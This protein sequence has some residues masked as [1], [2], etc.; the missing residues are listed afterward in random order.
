MRS[1]GQLAVLCTASQLRRCIWMLIC[2]LSGVVSLGLARRTA[3]APRSKCTR[4][5]FAV[6]EP[7]HASKDGNRSRTMKIALIGDIHANLVALSDLLEQITPLLEAEDT[8]D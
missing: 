2:A 4:H 7:H 5:R 8:L 3:L 1:L 6:W